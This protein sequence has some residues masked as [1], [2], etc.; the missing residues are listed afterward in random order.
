ML[1]YSRLRISSPPS[2]RRETAAFRGLLGIF[3][4]AERVEAL[5]TGTLQRAGCASAGEVAN[6]MVL[7]VLVHRYFDGGSVEILPVVGSGD[8]GVGREYDPSAV[9]SVGCPHS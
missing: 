5:R 8:W 1:L 4:G 3:M 2:V 7:N 9:S 6:R